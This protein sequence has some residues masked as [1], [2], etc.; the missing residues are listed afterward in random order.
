MKKLVPIWGEHQG[1]ANLY[2]DL[3]LKNKN[4]NKN[5]F[6]VYDIT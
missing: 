6:I 3:L 1:I 2:V 4:L 5:N